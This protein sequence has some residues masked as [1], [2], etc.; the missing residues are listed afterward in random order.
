MANWESYRLTDIV[1]KIQKNELVLPVIQ[2]NL[3]WTEEKIE[4][5]FDTLLKGDSFGGIMSIRD[6]R[7]KEPLFDFRSFIS[8]F[9]TGV[10]PKSDS[11]K[12]LSQD[13]SYVIDG[14]QRLQAFYIGLKGNYNNKSL[15]FDLF[16][17][18]SYDFRFS[19]TQDDLPK[20]VDDST[21]DKKR[22]AF[23]Y[24]VKDLLN[25]LITCGG[26]EDELADL[27]LDRYEELKLGSDNLEKNIKKFSKEIFTNKN[28]GICEV[29]KSRR[30]DR[31]EIRQEV[32][33][34][35]RRLNQGGTKLSALDLAASKLKGYD[36]SI[37]VFL[38]DTNSFTDIGF[39]QDEL[40]KLIFI[41]QDNSRKK[42]ASIDKTD[43]DFISDN[44]VRISKSL[45][46]LRKFLEYSKLEKYYK[47]RRP[48]IIPLYFIA[49]YVFHSNASTENLEKM[50]DDFETGNQ[51][52]NRLYNWL[53][54]SVLNRVFRRRG[55]GWIAYST[56]IRKILNT[57]KNH[58]G[59]SFPERELYDMYYN[60]P[61]DFDEE[62]KS[63]YLNDYDRDFLFFIVYDMP[64]E[65]RENDIDHIHPQ[66]LL[67]NKYDWQEINS[68]SNF[69]LLNSS[70]N[71]GE[72]SA[73]E[74]SA[75]IEKY[76]PNK[77]QYLKLH[78]IPE[79]KEL[80]DSAKFSDF[81]EERGNLITDKLKRRKR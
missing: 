62:I 44:K 14:Q 75:W 21:G 53:F 77:E 16:S 15:F 4:L 67:A 32:V 24:N 33:E 26:D 66:H 69:Q 27:L 6:Y 60:H 58:K 31:T 47:N 51:D 19:S 49:Y 76:V 59:E 13:I 56:G 71:R 42:I 68:V 20:E 46:T 81:L 52:F 78:L 2:R 65:F 1:E 55:A 48:S 5:L 11:S 37:E 43:A 25:E 57:V 12:K 72:K 63:E 28:I 73:K 80:W 61:L 38:N 17:D 64:K 41:L 8:E 39:E 35:F 9:K 34:L 22:K 29:V 23:W 45:K 79:D 3:V 40:L 18:D 54:L 36:S 7:D 30:R 74:L 10:Y 70:K 50:F